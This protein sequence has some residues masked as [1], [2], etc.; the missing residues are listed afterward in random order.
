MAQ[1]R[2]QNKQ[3]IMSEQYNFFPTN[4][5][6]SVFS[7]GLGFVISENVIPAIVLPVLFFCVGK[8]IDVFL[9]IYLE[10]RKNARNN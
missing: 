5:L 3:L 8:A 1:A 2:C 7:G 6:L 9:K 10:N 4:L